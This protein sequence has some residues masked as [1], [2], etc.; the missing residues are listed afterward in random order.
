M[1]V[2]KHFDVGF[3]KHFDVGLANFSQKFAVT[4]DFEEL[5]KMLRIDFQT[6][7]TEIRQNVRYCRVDCLL[8]L[9]QNSSCAGVF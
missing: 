4:V 7:L 3:R 8:A 6:F 9:H 5:K 2:R 1:G